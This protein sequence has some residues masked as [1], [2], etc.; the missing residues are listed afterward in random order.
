MAFEFAN[1]HAGFLKIMLHDPGGIVF[2]QRL[3]ELVAILLLTTITGEIQ[4]VKL[5]AKMYVIASKISPLEKLLELQRLT[6]EVGEHSS[7]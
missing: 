5:D 2:F 3:R 1:E 7:L 6:S 4:M